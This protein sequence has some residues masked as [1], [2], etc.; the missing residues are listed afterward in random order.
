MAVIRSTSQQITTAGTSVT[1]TAPAGAAA[2]D[3][4]LAYVWCDIGSSTIG[5]GSG[6]W[7]A[8]LREGGD[9]SNNMRGA[10]FHQTLAGAPDASYTFSNPDNLG[11]IFGV[12]VAINPETDVLNAITTSLNPQTGTATGTTGALTGVAGTAVMVY[13]FCVDD[14]LTISTPPATGTEEERLDGTAFDAVVYSE[15]DPGTGSL[16]RSCVWSF[17]T[18]HVNLAALLDYDAGTPPVGPE[19]TPTI[20]TTNGSGVS[21]AEAETD[22][23]TTANGEVLLTSCTDT[24][25]GLVLRYTGNAS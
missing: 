9:G 23:P 18:E 19:V 5:A 22:D 11:I 3:D 8:A 16:T 4:L 1:I 25:S 15:Q 10:L 12:L 2:G 6:S 20:D 17:S 24:L 21:T 7:G 14:T 13:G